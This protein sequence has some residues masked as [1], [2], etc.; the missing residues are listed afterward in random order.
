MHLRRATLP[1]TLVVGVAAL[2]IGAYAFGR[3]KGPTASWVR[4]MKF[5]GYGRQRVIYHVDQPAGLLNGRFRHLLQVAQN[6]VEAVGAENLD[7]RIVLQ[8]DGVDLLMW[9]KGNSAAELAID[10]LK[11][12]GVKFE[13]CRNTLIVRGLDPDRQLYG[14]AHGDVIRTAVGEIA[15][16][17]SQGFDYIKP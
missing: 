2:A 8:G 17:E 4:E 9:A 11:S 3:T 13:V 1:L 5:D 15:A 14:V 6:H 16:L 7:L 10:R 12:E